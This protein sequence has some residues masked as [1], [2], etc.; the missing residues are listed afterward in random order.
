MTRSV[1]KA[2]ALQNPEAIAQLQ[3]AI[4]LDPQF[5]M[6]YARIG[7]AYAVNWTRVD[8]GKP[9][10]EKAFQLSSGLPE[11]DKLY[12]T[13]W[14]EIANVIIPPL[15]NRFAKSWPTILWK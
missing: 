9:Y 6:A 13:S 4:A 1:E 8:E 7:Y 15:S 3:K 5:A 12:I 11:K 2:Q 10:L 14:Y